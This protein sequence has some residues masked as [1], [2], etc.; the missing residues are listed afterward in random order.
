MVC[1]FG[2]VEDAKPTVLETET[3][4]MKLCVFVDCNILSA[5]RTSLSVL[6]EKANGQRFMTTELLL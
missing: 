3:Q 4:Q 6:V 2:A 1:E 5:S